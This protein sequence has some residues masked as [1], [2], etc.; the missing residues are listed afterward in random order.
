MVSEARHARRVLIGIPLHGGMG[1]AMR[2]GYG[3]MMKEGLADGWEYEWKEV[4]G[5]GITAAR[6]YLAAKAVNEGFDVLV[7]LAG[8][9]GFRGDDLPAHLNRVLSH[10]KDDVRGLV[11]GGIYLFKQLPP[12]LV[13]D[14][15]ENRNIGKD[16]LLQ[17]RATGT[18]F[19]AIDVQALHVVIAKW[20]DVSQKLYGAIIPLEYDSNMENKP[21]A[22]GK[23]WNIFSQG[24][25]FSEDGTA[26]EWTTEDFY[27][28]RLVREAGLKVYVDMGIRL[29]HWGKGNYD[30]AQV[31]GIEE[32]ASTA[33]PRWEHS[34][35]E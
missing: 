23:A 29:Q 35:V 16:G 2:R 28:C 32:A 5:S 34:E 22:Q 21:K 8:D 10:F 9:I 19:M 14:Q 24:V 33:M 1:D 17:V 13:L 27:W 4:G 20:K 3:K 15:D 6:N 30:A 18:D 31:T 25:I 11:V 26:T 7:F 12:R